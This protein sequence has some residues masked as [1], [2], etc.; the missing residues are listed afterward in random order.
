MVLESRLAELLQGQAKKFINGF[1]AE[2]L[3]L[4]LLSGFLELRNLALNPEPLDELF[5]GSDLPFVVKAG[6]LSSAMLQL[7]LMQGEL[8]ILIDGLTL[9]VAPACKWLTREEVYQHRTN[10]MERLEFVHMRSQS[11]RRSLEREMFRKL[12]SDYLSRIK[13]TV[14][15]V[16]TR[17]EVEDELSSFGAGPP[18]ALGLVINSCDVTPVA[19]RSTSPGAPDGVARGEAEL[20]L[21]ERVQLKGLLLYQEGGAKTLVP[22]NLYQSTRGCELG[23]F[24]KLSQEQF[25]HMMDRTRQAHLAAASQLL[26]STDVSIKVDLKS[27]SL[28]TDCHVENCLT[29]EVVICLQNPSRLRVTAGIVEGM[30]WL[31]RRA[32]DFQMWPF[33]HALHGKPANGIGRW[34]VLRSFIHLKRRIQGNA[35]N[36]HDAIRMRMNCKEYIRLYKKKFN[37]PQSSFHWRRSLPP[38][39]AEDATRLGLIELSYPADKLVNFRMMAQTEMKTETSINSFAEEGALGDVKRSPRSQV[40]QVRE[41]TPMEQ[42]HLHGQHGFGANIFRGLPP[43]PSNLKVRIDIVAPLGLWWVCKLGKVADESSWTVALDAGRQPVRLLLV[44][45][46]SDNSVFGTLEV[47][48]TFSTTSRPV[49]VLLARSEVVDRWTAHCG[50]EGGK[51]MDSDGDARGF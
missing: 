40:W 7:S 23:I 24:Q 28:F 51:T 46:I 20:L 48:R 14:K 5:L 47:P 13:I 15:N 31:V 12:F 29:L 27:Q 50:V 17:F 34:H 25:I 36:L 9:V 32:L 49:A 2:H 6:T 39:T 1:N 22:W 11:Q 10:E 42:L 45:S 35:Y 8:E 26:P 3:N 18:L 16:H 4:G 33:L 19:T 21:A 38:L 30:R 41:L 37:G 44:D 43:P